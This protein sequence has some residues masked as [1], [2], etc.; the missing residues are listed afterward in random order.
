MNENVR[1]LLDRMAAL[2]RELEA[3]FDKELAVQRREFR[4]RLEKGR[5]A[6]DAEARALHDRLREGWVRF[7]WDAPLPSLLVAPV[8]YSL[9]LPLL[10]FDAWLW[11]YQSVCF[12]VYGIR[13]VARRRYVVLDRG[14]LKYLNWIE[15]FNCEYCGY[16]NGLIAHA[17]EIAAR[18]EQYFCPI[19]HSRPCP[20]VHERYG[21]FFDFGDAESYRGN[22]RKLRDELRPEK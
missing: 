21:E 18:T 15:R 8:I 11:V 20:G 9:L 12:P 13:K 14:Q 19:K 22:W 16:A 1:R 2:Q 4:Y 3:E 5:A 10:L 17:R 6:F 7:L